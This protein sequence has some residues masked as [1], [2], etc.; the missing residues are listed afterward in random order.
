MAVVYIYSSGC[1]CTRTSRVRDFRNRCRGT[2]HSHP[3][4]IVVNAWYRRSNHTSDHEPKHLTQ[5][6]DH[7]VQI[8]R[9]QNGTILS[10][11]YLHL[12]CNASTAHRRRKRYT[13]R[14]YERVCIDAY[15]LPCAFRIIRFLMI[16]TY[17]RMNLTV[18]I[19]GEFIQYYRRYSYLCVR[20]CSFA[21]REKCFLEVSCRFKWKIL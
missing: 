19:N 6:P 13:V 18:N 17:I 10:I 14:T 11:S 20:V 9:K 15:R 8:R 5:T 1:T 3:M 4:R 21:M 12:R 7:T 16:D 2:Q